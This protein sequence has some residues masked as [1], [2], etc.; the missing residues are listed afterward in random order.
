LSKNV[1]GG[2]GKNKNA[3]IILVRKP[4]GRNLPEKI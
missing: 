3:Y 4:A 1:V 2:Q